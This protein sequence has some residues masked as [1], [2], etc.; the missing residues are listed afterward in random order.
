[1]RPLALAKIILA[2][3]EDP[4]TLWFKIRNRH[5]VSFGLCS[6]LRCF[7]SSPEG[8]DIGHIIDVGANAGQFAKMAHFCW[9]S[10]RIDS[11]EPD[12]AAATAF[13]REHAGDDGI[14]LHEHALGSFSGQLTIHCGTTSGQNSPLVEIGAPRKSSFEA[15]V[16]RLDDADLPSEGRKRLLKIDVQ[17]Y[18][19]HVL[20]GAE[21]SLRT[22]DLILVELSFAEMFDGGALIEEV[23]ALL[24]QHGF[25]YLRV[26]DAY[27]D[28]R[29]G[30]VLQMDILFGRNA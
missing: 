1:M 7:A 14:V 25:K 30:V 12:R 10:A 5:M 16:L 4:V 3:A 19:M 13:R 11:F 2:S 15:K 26:M 8:A 20:R 17:G 6:S 9:P 29:S 21:N 22:L 24:R 28:H 27:R 23:W 18:E